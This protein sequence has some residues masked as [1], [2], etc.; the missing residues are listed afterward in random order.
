MKNSGEVQKIQTGL[1]IIKEQ[2][3]AAGLA[4]LEVIIHKFAPQIALMNDKIADYLGDNE[5]III[6]RRKDKNSAPVVITLDTSKYI[7]FVY[8]KPEKEIIDGH[9]STIHTLPEIKKLFTAEPDARISSRDVSEFLQNL[10]T[11][12]FDK[13]K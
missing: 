8:N 13:I 10:L 9:G 3:A 5:K 4:F 11:G 2:E 12:N 7:E 6:L 1:D